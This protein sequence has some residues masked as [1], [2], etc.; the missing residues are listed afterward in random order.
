VLHGQASYLVAAP[1]QEGFDTLLEALA[2]ELA[3]QFGAFLLLELWLSPEEAGGRSAQNRFC[4]HAPAAHPPHPMLE[5][6]ESALLAAT[7]HRKVPRVEI[8]YRSPMAA[9]R[10]TSSPMRPSGAASAWP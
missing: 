4:I 7:I 8:R 5:E 1:E 6:M 2:R 10:P 9:P 3:R